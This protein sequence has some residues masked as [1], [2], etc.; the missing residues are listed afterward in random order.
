MGVKYAGAE[1][2]PSPTAG[3]VSLLAVRIRTLILVLEAAQH[4][5]RD[6]PG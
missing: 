4:P 1:S 3:A 2:L 5:R 6:S